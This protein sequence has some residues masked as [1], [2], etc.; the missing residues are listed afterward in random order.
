MTRFIGVLFL[1]LLAL[2]TNC[3]AGGEKETI[4]IWKHAPLGL[5]D[6]DNLLFRNAYI[7]SYDPDRRIPEWVCYKVSPS[8]RSG[9]SEQASRF[10]PLREDPEVSNPVNYSE[11][12]ESGYERARLVP[13]FISG[14][15]ELSSSPSLETSPEER[16]Q[17][18]NYMTNIAPQ[19]PSFNHKRG[20]W[21]RIEAF[22]RDKVIDQAG[23]SFHV[24]DGCYFSEYEDYP[25]YP[26]IPSPR[27]DIHVPNG[28][29]RII[30]FRLENEFIPLAFDF[31]HLDISARA[32]L[33]SYL[34][35]IDAIEAKTGLDFFPLLDSEKEFNL[36]GSSTLFVWKNEIGPQFPDSGL[37][38]GS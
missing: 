24:V 38:D 6:H 19:I 8:E 11:Y 29:Y 3:L 2:L 32:D 22:L 5:P 30:V 10:M 17:D 9:A 26:P 13:A 12:L 37:Q 1:A 34:T 35:S 4:L 21:R 23:L 15:D 31:P 16:I 14:N 18:V 25:E 28:F 20:P 7:S 27:G 36:E 33:T